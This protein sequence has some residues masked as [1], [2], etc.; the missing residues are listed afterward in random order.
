MRRALELSSIRRATAKVD[1]AV[2]AL[3]R[4]QEDLERDELT[5]AIAGGSP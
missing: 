3:E 4:P 2:H 5:S 1:L